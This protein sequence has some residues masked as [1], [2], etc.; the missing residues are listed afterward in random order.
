MEKIGINSFLKICG[1]FAISRLLILF[2]FIIALHYYQAESV[3]NSAFRYS[4]NKILNCLGCWDSGWYLNI[5][6]NGY[7]FKSTCNDQTAFGFFPFYPISMKVLGRLT[8]DNY[9]AGIILSNLFLF[10]SSLFLFLL[11]L[12]IYQNRNTAMLAVLVLYFFPGSYLLSGIFSESAFMCLSIMCIYFFEAD[13]YFLC[14]IS[15]FLLTLTRPFGLLIL[16][17]LGLRYIF[18]N[19]LPFKIPVLYLLLVPMGII[20]F[21]AYCY[22]VTG[23]FLFYIHSKQTGWDIKNTLPWSTLAS[24]LKAP[25][26]YLRFNSIYTCIGLL[27]T[28]VLF[29]YVPFYLSIWTLLLIITPLSNGSANLICMVRYTIV[30]FPLFMMLAAFTGRYKAGWLLIIPISIMNL[31]LSVFFALGYQ[32]TA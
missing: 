13:D 4:D 12:R 24:G 25:E 9:L 18:K 15:G 7:S 2:A 3:K 1:L 19:G 22:F 28:L 5:A 21:F 16:L 17:P 31:I 8:G 11:S 29:R 30:C 10:L 23:D 20:S 14:G 32:F 26:P 6:T 27:M